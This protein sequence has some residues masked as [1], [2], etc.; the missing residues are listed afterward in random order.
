MPKSRH[1]LVSLQ[2]GFLITRYTCSKSPGLALPGQSMYCIPG[3]TRRGVWALPYSSIAWRLKSR[4]HLWPISPVNFT[5]AFYLGGTSL[6]QGQTKQGY[7]QLHRCPFQPAASCHGCGCCLLASELVP[8]L[9]LALHAGLAP[10]LT[11]PAEYPGRF[12]PPYTCKHVLAG[13]LCLLHRSH[14]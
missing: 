10:Q 5:T 4:A 12:N 7:G 3:S 11:H 14:R 6:S 1:T 8:V 13:G 2:G 9:R